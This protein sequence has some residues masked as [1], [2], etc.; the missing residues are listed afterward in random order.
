MPHSNPALHSPAHDSAPRTK[1]SEAVRGSHLA[2]FGLH[3]VPRA[4]ADLVLLGDLTGRYASGSY[5]RLSSTGTVSTREQRQGAA[6]H[7]HRVTAAIACHVARSGGTVEALARMLL[8]PDHEGGR[9]AQTIAMRSGMARAQG[10]IERVWASALNL[11]DTTA[12]VDSRPGVFESLAVLR[13]RIETTPW[14]GERGRTALRVLQA[15]LSF[16]QAAGGRMHAASE[17][18]AAEAAGISRQTLRQAYRFVLKP[19]GWLRR[20][21]VGHGTEGST[22][23]LADGLPDPALSRDQPIQ[24]PPDEDLG[25]WS[26]PETES[27][28]DV[29][30]RVI[31]Q[32]MGHDAFAHGALG[33]SALMVIGAL[34]AHPAQTPRQL[35]ASASVSRATAYRTLDR[36]RS[37]G[38]VQPDG[39]GWALTPHAL[40]GIGNS[41]PEAVTGPPEEPDQR[42]GWAAMALA[43]GTAGIA[44][45]R[46]AL[47][48][49]ER[50]AYR[51]ALQA[52]AQ[53]RRPARTQ[54]H[55][56]RTVLVPAPRA[57]E[58]PAHWQTPDGAV[59]DPV[60][61]FPVPGWQV[62]TDGHL[63]LLSPSDE[64]SYAELAAAHTQALHEWESAA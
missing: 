13:E 23:Y 59:L 40:E 57:D 28:A 12:A 50:A 54:V 51:D 5:T 26:T 8:H 53:R 17:R 61:G 49:T 31:G 15:H 10:Y 9:H 39:D 34:H 44:A 43:Y 46:K 16:A 30:S 27:R 1:P 21:R 42:Q 45:A 37:H 60:T 33:S 38:L 52:W 55:Q 47:H 22:W 56:G 3:Q 24:C 7:G 35:V 18:Q 14:R 64:L 62:A 48:A 25:E 19:G 36:L 4:A 2:T 32:L 58:V 29:D 11:V 63:I 41:L 20:L 6:E